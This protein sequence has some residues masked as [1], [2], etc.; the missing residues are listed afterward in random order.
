MI[1]GCDTCRRMFLPLFLLFRIINWFLWLRSQPL[2]ILLAFL[3]C[4]LGSFAIKSFSSST[5]SRA[6]LEPRQDSPT[7]QFSAAG[8]ASSFWHPRRLGCFELHV[9]SLVFVI[10]WSPCLLTFVYPFVRWLR[11]ILLLIFRV[12]LPMVFHQ[13]KFFVKEF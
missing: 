9:L 13:P 10:C 4:I 6:L 3:F 5:L 11:Q 7:E 12:V 1:L 2:F 8:F